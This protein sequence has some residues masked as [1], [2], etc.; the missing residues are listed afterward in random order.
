MTLYVGSRDPI[1]ATYVMISRVESRD[2]LLKILTQAQIWVHCPIL[3]GQGS[4]KVL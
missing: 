3:I 1:P 2:P 4:Q